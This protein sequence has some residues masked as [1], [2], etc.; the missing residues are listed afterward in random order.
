MQVASRDLTLNVDIFSACRV[1]EEY[2]NKRVKYIVTCERWDDNFEEVRCK[3]ELSRNTF[4]IFADVKGIH[5]HCFVFLFLWKHI[6]IQYLYTYNLRSLYS[7]FLSY[8]V[9]CTCTIN[10][11]GNTFAYK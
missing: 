8:A 10:S 6:Y 4:H 7:S 9:L 1:L 2:M 3:A 11:I 5:E